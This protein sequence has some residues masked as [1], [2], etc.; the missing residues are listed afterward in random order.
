MD[1]EIVN[2]FGRDLLVLVVASVVMYVG[3]NAADLG[4]PQEFV[5]LVGA[6]CLGLYRL[7][8]T[9]VKGNIGSV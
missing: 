9:K 2:R 8:R 3:N 4:V 1:R 7:L 6:T 5:P